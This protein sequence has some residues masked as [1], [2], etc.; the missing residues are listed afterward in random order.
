MNFPER[1]MA[2]DDALEFRPCFLCG[3]PGWCQHREIEVW[4]AEMRLLREGM[5]AVLEKTAEMNRRVA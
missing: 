4:M 1:K 5:A 2:S 3:K